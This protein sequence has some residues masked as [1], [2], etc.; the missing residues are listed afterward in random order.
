MRSPS[1]GSMPVVAVVQTIV[2]SPSRLAAIAAAALLAVGV[3][4]VV[5]AAGGLAPKTIPG[6]AI[7]IVPVFAIAAYLA[8]R[9]W[10]RPTVPL[11]V[12]VALLM[13]AELVR[14]YPHLDLTD[15]PEVTFPLVMLVLVILAFFEPRVRG[16]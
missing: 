5:G 6:W 12:L 3:V 7:F 14:V 15:I 13:A 1:T 8:Y 10:T 16:G 2:L 4:G 11:L 9:L